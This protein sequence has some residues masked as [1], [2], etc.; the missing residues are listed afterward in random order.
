MSTEV[1]SKSASQQCNEMLCL[2]EDATDKNYIGE[3]V[4]QLA[5]A[6]QCAQLAVESGADD[7]TV[8]AALFHDIG[9][10]C[11]DA[12][13]RAERN[14]YGVMNHDMIGA[15]FLRQCGMSEKVCQLVLGHVE[16][17]RYLTAIDPEYRTHLSDA[18]KMT[19]IAQG[20]GMRPEEVIAFEQ[21]PLFD[22]K[23]LMRTWDEAAKVVDLAVPDLNTYRPLL[24]DH[25]TR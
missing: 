10:L 5:H 17:K 3:S 7:E 22:E 14:T 12:D 16:A 4:S 25:L 13:E 8:L 15:D 19:L 6:L 24:F 9:H 21:D 20:D 11:A 2:L 23:I 18:S 1:C